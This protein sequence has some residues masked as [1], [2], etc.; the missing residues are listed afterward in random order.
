MSYNCDNVR[1]PYGEHRDWSE[2]PGEDVPYHERAEAYSQRP[3][4]AVRAAPFQG[5]CLNCLDDDVRDRE[6]FDVEH[7]TFASLRSG[8]ADDEARHEQ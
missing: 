4:E 6:M 2:R 3:R 7:G 8:G 1:C 5:L